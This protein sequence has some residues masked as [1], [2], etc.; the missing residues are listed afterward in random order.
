MIRVSLPSLAQTMAFGLKLG[1]LAEPGDIISMGGGLG[2]GKTT[3]TKF[4]GQGLGVPDHSYITSPTFSIIH[5][6]LGGRIP[7]YHMDL[8]RLQG[9][10]LDELGLEDY[11]YGKGLCIVE[12]P[13]RL[14]DMMPE[15]R[16]HVELE[17]NS[18]TS[19]SAHLTA[20]GNFKDRLKMFD[21]QAG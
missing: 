2:A 13:D 18:K 20:Y 8:Y 16:L 17:I 15:D 3:L 7:L 4:I 11:L 14:N 1:R 19:R 12:W 5:E 21:I 9:A 6:Y 10:D